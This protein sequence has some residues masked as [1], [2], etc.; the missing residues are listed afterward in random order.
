MTF[1]P[2]VSTVG[3]CPIERYTLV[4][5]TSWPAA[6]RQ[7]FTFWHWLLPFLLGW[8]SSLARDNQFNNNIVS[9]RNPAPYSNKAT[10][11]RHSCCYNVVESWLSPVWRSVN[12]TWPPPDCRNNA[13]EFCCCAAVH[14]WLCR[15]KLRA[16]PIYPSQ[17]LLYWTLD[18]SLCPQRIAGRA[19]WPGLFCK[20]SWEWHKM[21][22]EYH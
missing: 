6:G 12:C 22:P 20:I 3:F 5:R 15:K 7:F 14:I 21:R 19:L 16:R 13:R 9:C 18:F 2:C 1:M 8:E 17:P 4:G 10:P 11:A